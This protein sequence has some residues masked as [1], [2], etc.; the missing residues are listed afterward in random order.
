MTTRVWRAGTVLLLG[1][2]MA[3]AA[4]AQQPTVG[5]GVIFDGPQSRHLIDLDTVA[6]E[7]DALIGSE[8]R[9][10]LGGDLQLQGD[11]TIAGA[12]SALERQFDDE[13][14]DLV[15]TIGV[16]ATQAAAQAATLRKPVIGVV[17]ADA[18]LQ[19]FPFAAGA[20]GKR[21]FVYLTSF[22]SVDTQLAAFRRAVRFERLGVLADEHT[23]AALPALRREKAEQIE[24]ALGVTV[25]VIAVGDSAGDIA[26]Q[27]DDFDAVYVT[28]LLRLDA[29]A[30]ESLAGALRDRRI[31]T[32]S[33]LGGRE[34]EFGFL[35][36][37]GGGEREQFVLVR[38]IALNIQRILLGDAPATIPVGIDFSDR[39]TIN[40][41]VARAIGYEPNFAVLADARLINEAT[42]LPASRIGFRETLERA[43]DRNTGLRVAGFGPD[44]A[45]A[46]RDSARSGLL[47]QLGFGASRTRIDADRAN[48]LVQP[49]KTTDLQLSG[50]QL[51]Y[52]DDVI[53]NW[54]AASLEVDAATLDYRSDELD[55]VQAAGEAY[56]QVL[57]ADALYRVRTANV[58]TT[59]ENLRLAR[60]RLAIGFSGRSD[61]LRWESQLATERRDLIAAE[62]AVR[63]A[64][65][66]LAQLLGDNQVSPP[67]PVADSADDALR[68]FL[69]PQF[70]R[71]VDSPATWQRFR[72][73]L[74][75]EALAQ[76]PELKGLDARIEGQARQRLAA[77]R[78]FYLPEV[79]LQGAAGDRISASG[80]G[81]D[82]SLVNQDDESWSV[83]VTA[84]WPV[85]TGGAL[86]ARLNA[87]DTRLLQLQAR[88][89]ALAEQ[90][91][92]RMRLVLFDTA[93]SFTAIDLST[94]A[95]RAAAENLEIVVDA[96]AKGAA[97][98]TDLLEAQEASLTARLGA[99]DARY[100]YLID[101]LA[102]LRA[103]GDFR[104][105]FEPGYRETFLRR[106]S[107]YSAAETQP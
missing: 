76:A 75:S 94:E 23:L 24:E 69:E 62:A 6:R 51:L 67:A 3:A 59:R 38:R 15:L 83:S 12:A 80:A 36:N 34:L 81:S 64:G 97:S 53:A 26:R 41:A 107:Q 73:F 89:I 82:L 10:I 79:A 16:L 90:I 102:V 104:L 49:E 91:E 54:R 68:F 66:R 8:Y 77:Q 14:V 29:R 48:P 2:L 9:V 47:P 33:L 4:A 98:I 32:F 55:I 17:V 60:I 70:V 92:L 43:A 1:T 87:E 88:R 42:A 39:L 46:Q 31:P 93:A 85:F 86:R 74:V 19:D 57:R 37:L 65:V 84:S 50:Q 21:N 99:A 63:Q 18:E 56:L 20:S 106:A 72:N 101:V 27:L 44:L 13:R 105:V 35:M 45:A 61:V 5:V 7:V 100:Q 103:G 11:W 22:R 30:M 78:K 96:Y 28:P 52:S 95:A 71:L 25:N 40:M 58:E